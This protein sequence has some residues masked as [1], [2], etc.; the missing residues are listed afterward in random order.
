MDYYYWFIAA[1]AFGVIEI[2]TAGFFVFWFGIGA[3]IV[4]L[5]DLIGLHSL[6]LQ[7]IVFSSISV[8][9][10]TLSKTFFKGV[11]KYSEAKGYKTSMES[12]VGKT[13]RVTVEISSEQS[14]GRV[15]V[16]GQDWTAR[17]DDNS[18]IPLDTI[19]EISRVE[20]AK[21]FVHQK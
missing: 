17:S 10:V 13:G 19:V 8:I 2:F 7:T 1:L 14:T 11:F 18:I 15:L 3:A 16:E 6:L 9:L 20:G 4:G 5:L 12:L 21:L